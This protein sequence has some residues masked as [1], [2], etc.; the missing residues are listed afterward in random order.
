MVILKGIIRMKRLLL[1]LGLILSMLFIFACQSLTNISS[2][3]PTQP[4]QSSPTLVADN[5]NLQVQPTEI[6]TAEPPAIPNLVAQE[7][8]LV[9]IY[10]NASRGVVAIR[11]FSESGGGLGSGFVIDRN[12]HIITNFHVI[13]GVDELE[14]DFSSGF[15]TRGEVIGSDTDSDLAVIKVEAPSEELHPLIL[16]DSSEIQVGQTVV[17]IGNP[18]GLSG[19]MTQGIVSSFGRTLQSLREAPGGGLFTA[20]DIIQTDAAINPG[21]SGGPLL[22]LD[23]EVIGVNRAIRTFNFTAG[24]EPLNSGVG[25]AIAINLVKRVVP[26]LISES[27][28]D[29]PYLGITSLDDLSLIQQEALNLSQSNGAYVMAVTPGSPAD[30]A[31]LIGGETPTD[32]PGLNSGGDLITAI[33]DQ[34]VYQF[35]DLLSYLLNYKS[36][37]DTV[38]LTILRDG[39]ELQ[40]DLVLGSRP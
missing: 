17:A 10:E 8:T 3:I 4:T 34:T 25:F 21:N 33:D 27:T 13:E 19:T 15:K 6:P 24:E 11:V 37:G 31:G 9:S 39:Q 5:I 2:L 26:A 40:L 29:Y 28:Y 16:G 23:G 30:D 22:N 1:S 38:T 20:G 32:I 12:G 18:F 36:P 7:D 14:V 35:S